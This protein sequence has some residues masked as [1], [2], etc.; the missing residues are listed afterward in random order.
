MKLSYRSLGFAF[1]SACRSSPR[2]SVSLTFGMLQVCRPDPTCPLLMIYH[3]QTYSYHS[4]SCGPRHLWQLLSFQLDHFLHVVSLTPLWICKG[5][6][7]FPWLVRTLW[8]TQPL[9]CLCCSSTFDLGPR[10]KTC[11]PLWS[12]R[13]QALPLP[14]SLRGLSELI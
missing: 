5:H 8:R 10:G 2:S 3:C 4:L 1:L 6:R 13:N 7:T 14:W 12:L 11:I 9:V